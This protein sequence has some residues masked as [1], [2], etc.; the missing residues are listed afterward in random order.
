MTVSYTRVLIVED[1]FLVS[2]M[3]RGI[4]EGMGY[5]VAGTAADGHQAIEMTQS[6]RPDV[7]LMDIGLPNMDGVE[8][9]RRIYESCPT[10]IVV[11]TA[12]DAMELVEQASAAIPETVRP[13]ARRPIK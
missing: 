10:P 2:E 13:K 3:I 8:A 6:I 1:D 4:L 7:I 11:L 9:T 5:I 12:Y